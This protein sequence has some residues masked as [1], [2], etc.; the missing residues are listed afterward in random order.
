MTARRRHGRRRLYGQSACAGWRIQ[1]FGSMDAY[2]ASDNAPIWC[3]VHNRDAW[4]C[5]THNPAPELDPH[6]NKGS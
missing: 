6:A 3:D 1:D 2:L 5:F 4:Q